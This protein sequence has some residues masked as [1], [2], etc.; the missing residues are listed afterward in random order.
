MIVNRGIKV[1]NAILSDTKEF[2]REL[3]SFGL[4]LARSRPERQLEF[5]MFSE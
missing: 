1:I 4:A 2:L 3:W 5:D